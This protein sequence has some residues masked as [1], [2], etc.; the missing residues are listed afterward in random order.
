MADLTLD[1]AEV[2]IVVHY[3]AD[4]NGFFWH[5]RVL[6]HR[7]AGGPFPGDIVGEIY[8]HDPIG[9]AALAGFKREAQIQVTILGEGDIENI[10][11]FQWVVAE[12]GRPD[13]GNVVDAALLGNEATGLA[14]MQKG[15]V[16][17]SGEELFV[18]RVMS[19]DLVDWRRQ[20]ALISATSGFLETID[21]EFPIHGV[22]AA[23]KEFH[24]SVAAS[25]GEFLV[26]HAEWVRL[27]GVSKKT[28]AAHIHRALCEAL[29]LMHSF[30]QID[31]SAIASG[32]HLTRW[33]IQTELAVERNPQQPDFSGL[34]II[35]GTAQL[36]DGRDT[37]SK[38]TDWV[39]NRLKERA[40]IWKQERLYNQERRH[41]RGPRGG[42]AD[43]GDS[44][45]DEE[46]TGLT[47][48]RKKKKKKKGGKGE[49][50]G[51]AAGA[52]EAGQFR[53]LRR[54]D[55]SLRSL[56]ILAA[57]DNKKASFGDMPFTA[58][59]RWILEDVTRRVN[60]YGGCPPE[61]T[62]Q[63]A[64]ADLNQRA[65]LYEQE[66]GQLVPFDLDKD[67]R[68][69]APPEVQGYIDH[70]ADLP[71]TAPDGGQ[72]PEQLRL[73]AQKVSQKTLTAYHNHV[74][75]FESW[76]RQR[77]RRVTKANLDKMV[78]SYLTWLSEGDETD[79]SPGAYLSDF[80]VN[81][82]EA[83][84]GWKKQALGRMRMP[85]PEE[86]VYDLATHALETGHL[87]VCETTK[88]GEVDD[89]VLVADLGDRDWL[90]QALTAWVAR[91]SG[92]LF[93]KLRLARLLQKL[94]RDASHPSPQR[95]LQRRVPQTS[96]AGGSAK[97][98]S[99]ASQKECISIREARSPSEALAR[100]GS[101][102]N[103]VH[104]KQIP[105]AA[106]KLAASA[107]MTGLAKQ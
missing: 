64:L 52:A 58:V 2:Q 18:E 28:S 95:G 92:P 3:P 25:A 19:K 107:A 82:K 97:A 14:F 32:E 13:F 78:T 44:S 104:Q 63:A 79:P 10:E 99:M 69:L 24:E 15:V 89:S 50:S 26:Y 38:F 4:E 23:K 1:I 29:R 20:K 88:T 43:H 31:T 101:S 37:T 34:D 65:N 100:S 12:A 85:V 60:Q 21:K 17:V 84:A 90:R 98:R 56:N 75:D 62:E 72:L 103:G 93:P 30:D 27:S 40:A 66:A 48:A 77:G 68:G 74:R 16:I 86:F 42:R 67:A 51:D 71:R 96:K 9:A 61:I 83:L 70:F 105:A 33:L 59:Q 8:A 45:D 94:L 11:A 57:A 6:L 5:H 102:T 80:L 91:C 81:S 106:A 22:R 35:S 39:S 87:D 55:C 73:R 54:V 47:G 76:A 53:R 7:I 49:G 41:L 46:Q 36:P